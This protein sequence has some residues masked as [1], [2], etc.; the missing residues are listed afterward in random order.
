MKLKYIIA[1]SLPAH[2]KQKESYQDKTMINPAY[3]MKQ[4]SLEF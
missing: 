2:E 3:V 4:H 1:S